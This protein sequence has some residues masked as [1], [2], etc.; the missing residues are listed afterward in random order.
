[1]SSDKTMHY[2][3][4]L[5]N[6]MT[7]SSIEG[8]FKC[9]VGDARC[10]FCFYDVSSDEHYCSHSGVRLQSE[11]IDDVWHEDQIFGCHLELEGGSI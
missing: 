1:M 6:A 11:G 4:Q 5:V 9:K 10:S 3:N 7:V 2:R 8:K